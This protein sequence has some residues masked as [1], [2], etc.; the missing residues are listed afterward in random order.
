MINLIKNMYHSQDLHGEFL[1]QP[2]KMYHG[3]FAKKIEN[4]VSLQKGAWLVGN[5]VTG[6]FAYPIFGAL[7]ALGLFVKL[8]GIHDLRKHNESQKIR[9]DVIHSGV[10]SGGGYATDSSSSLIKSGWQMNVVSEFKV[11]KQNI[12]KTYATMTQEVD[13]LSNQYKKIYISSKGYVNNDEGE[14]TVQLTISERV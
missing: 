8:T 13:S 2:L 5:V 7:A 6:I 3:F 14:I 9:L 11:T 1:F 12:E 10:N 4:S